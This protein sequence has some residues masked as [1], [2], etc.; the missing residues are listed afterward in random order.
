MPS[1]SE[2]V[3]TT[4]GSVPDFRAS[5][6]CLRSCWDT[7]PWWARA[8]IGLAPVAAPDWAITSAGALFGAVGLVVD[9]GLGV[10]S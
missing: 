9:L 10:V 8:M 7:L 2:L 6:I 1:S 4:A 5:S 3:A